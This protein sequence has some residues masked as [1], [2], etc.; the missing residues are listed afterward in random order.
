MEKVIE[1]YELNNGEFELR[2]KLAEHGKIYSQ[3][4]KGFAVDHEEIF[5]RNSY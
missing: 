3:A 5:Q 4:L 2:T 1:V